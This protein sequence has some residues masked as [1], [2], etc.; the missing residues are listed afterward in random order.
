MKTLNPDML[1]M[2]QLRD[3]AVKASIEQ[4]ILKSYGNYKNNYTNINIDDYPNKIFDQT[5]QYLIIALMLIIMI[6]IKNTVK[7]A[8]RF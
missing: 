3:R 7:M 2:K 5:S 4:K 8:Q 1:E 6:L